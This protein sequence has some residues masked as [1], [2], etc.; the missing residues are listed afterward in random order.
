M[1]ASL[2]DFLTDTQKSES[3]TPHKEIIP[4]KQPEIPPKTQEITG[5]HFSFLNIFTQNIT[6]HC[7]LLPSLYSQQSCKL[8]LEFLTV[9]YQKSHLEILSHPDFLIY[10]EFS[11]NQV[12]IKI[13]DARNI[14][15]F[16]QN[17]GLS[18]KKVIIID[19]I[20]KS[21]T[22]ALNCLL[23][24]IEE[25]PQ[26]TVFYLIY[27]DINAIPLTIK[28]RGI[29][30]TDIINNEKDFK[31]ITDFFEIQNPNFQTFIQSGYNFNIYNLTTESQNLTLTQIKKKLN[32]KLDDHT[33]TQIH[34]FLEKTL[35]KLAVKSD[36]FQKMQE[37]YHI[38]QRF[39]E[40]QKSI[41]HLNTNKQMALIEIVERIHNI[42]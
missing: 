18:G 17:T 23:K 28:S 16:A 26:N 40:L 34:I 15:T 11:N 25:P 7:V 3:L 14:I 20:D 39:T 6:H 22:N 41:K 2:F 1:D 9:K 19:K 8:L 12:P 30:I 33:T 29:T 35:H 32:E 27:E 42:V 10:T 4:Q 38:L 13:E 31:E 21:T 5:K 37:I 36:S 24:I